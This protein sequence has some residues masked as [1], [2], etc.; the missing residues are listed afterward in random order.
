MATFLP[1]LWSSHL[2]LFPETAW[3][4]MLC[5]SRYSLIKQNQKRQTPPCTSPVAIGW[6]GPPHLP[7]CSTKLIQNTHYPVCAN[8]GGN[9]EGFLGKRPLLHVAGIYTSSRF[10]PLLVRNDSSVCCFAAFLCIT[11]TNEDLITAAWAL[12]VCF[13]CTSAFPV[14][15]WPSP[16]KAFSL[17][18]SH[19]YTQFPAMW[20]PSVYSI[21]TL[22]VITLWLDCK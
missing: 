4:H 12:F 11:R 1:P 21:E 6:G 22:S 9:T 5:T 20:D 8:W 18:H 17:A 10:W 13:L 3:K 19:W 15:T 16:L 14:F 2:F 7:P